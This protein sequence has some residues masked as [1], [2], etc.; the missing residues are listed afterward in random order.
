MKAQ[1]GD[2]PHGINIAQRVRCRN[3]AVKERIVDNGREKI[4][5]LDKCI[6][7]IQTVDSGVIGFLKAYQYIGVFKNVDLS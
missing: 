4:H 6:L 7:V 1:S 2:S 5:G 3:L